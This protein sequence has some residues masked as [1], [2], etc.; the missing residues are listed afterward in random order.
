LLAAFVFYLI[1]RGKRMQK[2]IPPKEKM[3]NTSVDFADT[4][5]KLYLQYGQHK[6][7]VFQ[8]EKNLLNHIRSRYY[9]HAQKADEEYMARVSVKSGIP[10]EK[11]SRIFERFNK[12]KKSNYATANDV[13]EIYAE[14]E[15]FYKNCK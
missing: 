5:S 13:V 14:I 11:I 7:I 3:E 8:Q 6:Y 4:M 2:V 10:L 1:F 12:V 15:Y 9:I